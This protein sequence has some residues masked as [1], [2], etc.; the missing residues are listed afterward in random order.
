MSQSSSLLGPIRP[1]LIIHGGAGNIT[2]Q[3]IPPVKLEAYRSSL[4]SILRNSAKLLSNPNAR[5]LDV[6]VHAVSLLEDD[7]LFNCGKGAVFTSDGTNEL[8][9][10]IMVSN[11]YRKRGVGC[12]LLR[13]VKNPIKLAKEMLVRGEEVDGG[14]GGGHCQLSGE[15]LEALAEKWGLELVDPSYFWTKERWDQHKKGLERE[16]RRELSACSTW[17]PIE[18]VPQGTVG[19]VVLDSTGTIA[20]CASTG[21]LTNKLRG[22]IGDTPTVGAGFWAEEWDQQPSQRMVYRPQLPPLGPIENISRG[23]IT[24]L[25]GQCFAPPGEDSNLSETK[26]V[27]V[28]HAV[29]LSGTG[30]G[31]SFLRLSAART[32]AAMSRF[33]YPNQSL[34]TA[35]SLVAGPGGELQRSAGDRWNKTGEGEAG[36]IAIELVGREANISFDFNRGMF[37]AYLDDNGQEVFAAFRDD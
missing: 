11:G 27:S 30:N 31:D 2:R 36:I 24:S 7:E 23:N 25:I 19:A 34:A 18:Y 13:R 28:R 33:S 5:A 10:S 22:R 3:N 14:G 21:G 26:P 35:V 17:D 12:S 29:G 20:T 9:A 1:R 6:A 16:K 32:T 37:R 15:A 8:E 4:L